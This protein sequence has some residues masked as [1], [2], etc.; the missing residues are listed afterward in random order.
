MY[1]DRDT[2]GLA[3]STT[4]PTHWAIVVG[5]TSPC[6][7]QKNPYGLAKPQRNVTISKGVDYFDCDY[8]G[9][10]NS[11]LLQLEDFP[12]PRE[13]QARETT[14]KMYKKKQN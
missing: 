13:F 11:R 9:P 14:G 1:G 10:T 8:D 4:A 7:R 2:K 5:Y 3:E 12:F 6:F